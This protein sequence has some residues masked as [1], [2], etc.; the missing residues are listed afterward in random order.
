MSPK[1]MFFIILA[2]LGLLLAGGGLVYHRTR[3]QLSQ[4][5]DS[6]G[7]LKADIDAIDDSIEDVKNVLAQ[8]DDLA[9]INEIASD[10]LPPSKVQSDLVG[11]LYT[12]ANESGVLIRT[13]NFVSPEGTP[14]AEPNLTQTKPL[15]GV[16]GVFVLPINLSYETGSYSN[17]VQFLKK[18]EANRRKLQISR[19]GVNPVKDTVEGG[20]NATQVTGYQGDLEINVYVRP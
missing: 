16:G 7:E 11:Q 14:T 9:F 5:S 13:L 12:L 1:Q 3:G 18:I 20:G 19:L 10:V 4:K 6:L 15:E 17:F 8:Y 2:V